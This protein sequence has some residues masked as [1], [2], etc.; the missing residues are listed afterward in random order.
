MHPS[1]DVVGLADIK[2]AA[3]RLQGVAL[4]TPLLQLP[5]EGGDAQGP[6]TWLKPE[7]LQ[8]IGAF[9]IRGAYNALSQLDPA[10][11]AAGVVT[12]SSGNHAQGIARAARLLG[13]KAVIAM[14]DDAPAVKIAGVLA[15]GAEI[16]FVG[17]DNEERIVRADELAADR[18]LV[19]IPSYDDARIVAGQGTVGL[20]IIQQ[21]AETDGPRRPLTV[22]A[23]IGGGGLSSGICIAAKGLRDDVTVFGVEPELAADAADSMREG[24]VV[25]WAPA[26][27]G[28]T[29]ADG[30]RT[31]ALGDIPFAILDRL[32]D[33][34]VTVSEQQIMAAMAYAAR[35]ARLVVE[36]SGAIT[37]AAWQAHRDQLP[38]DAD[39]VIVIS[40]GNVDPEV[41][42]ALVTEGET[43]LDRA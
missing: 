31:S 24:R 26:L 4:R 20:E 43:L 2:A 13:I 39:T 17:A 40:G 28:R 9:K 25:R 16:D 32:L 42:R 11:R 30:V 8:P 23:P 36:P 15:D 1:P 10:E 21:V 27:T 38:V 41:Y 14:P 6:R 22:L 33:G 35:A 29:I 7:S 3:L 37:V 12:H 18:G 19:L 34:V 5:P